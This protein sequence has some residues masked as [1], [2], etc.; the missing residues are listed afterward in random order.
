MDITT[1]SQTELK[2]LAYD[3]LATIETAQKNLQAINQQLQKFGQTNEE[4]V[5]D[6][7]EEVVEDEK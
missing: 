6:V 5:E 7:T 3:Q 4:V 1:L 2:A